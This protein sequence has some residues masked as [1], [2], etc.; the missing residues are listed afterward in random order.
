ML[1]VADDG[2]RLEFI[3]LPHSS[4]I[5]R[6][7]SGIVTRLSVFRMVP[8]PIVVAI[9]PDDPDEVMRLV[10][11]PGDDAGFGVVDRGLSPTISNK[12]NALPL[13]GVVDMG[14]KKCCG[15]SA[16]MLLQSMVLLPLAVTAIADNGK[17]F[18]NIGLLEYGLRLN[19]GEGEKFPR[20]DG[21]LSKFKLLLITLA[22]ELQLVTDGDCTFP[23]RI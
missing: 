10:L 11:L 15:S 19:T 1:G 13:S 2:N 9:D 12:V 8:L 17:L 21:E 7:K 20:F 6:V 22:L 14:R 23:L 16:P 18:S 4:V 5:C 3:I